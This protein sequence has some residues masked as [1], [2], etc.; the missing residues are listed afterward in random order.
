MQDSRIPS[1]STVSERRGLEV[2]KREVEVQG[3]LRSVLRSESVRVDDE[4]SGTVLAKSLITEAACYD[5]ACISSEAG[6]EYWVAV[7]LAVLDNEEARTCILRSSLK[8]R[9]HSSV[10][11]IAETT[12]LSACCEYLALQSLHLSVCRSTSSC[13]R[14]ALSALRSDAYQ[15]TSESCARSRSSQSE[16]TAVDN[17][18]NAL[19]HLRNDSAYEVEA[20]VV[21]CLIAHRDRDTYLLRNSGRYLY[22]CSSEG[23]Y[24]YL[25]EQ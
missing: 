17:T 20:F 11:H 4:V 19:V 15:R 16:N 3:E 14:Y 18:A 25:C 5:L 9:E 10:H 23:R 8:Q 13:E 12:H 6:H 2:G 21:D 7:N 22:L 24:L 1:L